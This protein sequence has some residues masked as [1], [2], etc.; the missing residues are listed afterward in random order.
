LFFFGFSES[1]TCQYKDYTDTFFIFIDRVSHAYSLAE[2]QNQCDNERFFIC[3]SLNYES[4]S[5]DCA[6]S[7]NDLTSVESSSNALHLRRYSLFSEKSNYEQVSV[8]CSQQEMMLT[9]NF[10][11]PFIGRVYAKGNPSQC[12]VVGT[13][14][15]RLHF[16]I[17]LGSRC[18]TRQEVIFYFCT[19]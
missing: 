17:P 4:Y 14:Q 8:H 13:G 1:T 15:T 2:C 19:H 12:F 10:D 5:K 16:A 11:T 18:G 9:L 6:L 7:S 3:R